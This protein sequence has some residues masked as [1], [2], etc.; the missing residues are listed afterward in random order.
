LQALEGAVQGRRLDAGGNGVT[1]QTIQP[2]GK[3]RLRR[4]R[5]RPR[6]WFRGG[7]WSR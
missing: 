4:D 5:F 6:T 3:I 7:R 2:A 1:A